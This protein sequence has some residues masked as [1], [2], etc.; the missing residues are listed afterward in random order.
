MNQIQYGKLET[1]EYTIEKVEL[2]KIAV[3]YNRSTHQ[4]LFLFQIVEG[5][6]ERLEILLISMKKHSICYC[7]STKADV[8]ILIM[9]DLY[10]KYGLNIHQ[11]ILKK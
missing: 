11:L 9:L 7:P 2:E 3:K 5:D 1:Y 10:K 8:H 6:I 4:L